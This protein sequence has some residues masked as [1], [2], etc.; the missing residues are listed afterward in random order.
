MLQDF[1]LPL[2]FLPFLFSPFLSLPILF[3]LFVAWKH[4]LTTQPG[5]DYNSILLVQPP[6]YWANMRSIQG[7]LCATP[8][9][10]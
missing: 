10:L 5:L 1:L 8:M 7:P 4:C 6:K 2:L 3:I 9:I